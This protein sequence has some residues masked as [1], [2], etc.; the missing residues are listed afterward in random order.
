MAKPSKPNPST[1]RLYLSDSGRVTEAALLRVWPILE[2]MLTL[3]YPPFRADTDEELLEQ[4]LVALRR[5]VVELSSLQSDALQQRWSDCLRAHKTERWPVIAAIM[6]TDATP[7][8]G[9]VAGMQKRETEADAVGALLHNVL[10]RG[11]L[12]Q[13][14]AEG[15]W[16]YELKLFLERNARV[17]NQSEIDHMRH[18]FDRAAATMADMERRA[19]AGEE[20]SGMASLRAVFKHMPIREARLAE[21]ILKRAAA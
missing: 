8:A 6:E 1:V 9:Y 17:P 12:G 10:Y 3:F 5:Y 11:D 18:G 19:E 14:A 16:A 15:G 4:T 20:I 21:Q 7:G 2:E 13:R